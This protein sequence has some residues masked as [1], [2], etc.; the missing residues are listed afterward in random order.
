MPTTSRGSAARKKPQQ[1]A[2]ELR[3]MIVSGQLS[4]GDSLGHEPELVERFG[5]SRPSLRL[6]FVAERVVRCEQRLVWFLRWFRA[7]PSQ[8]MRRTEYQRFR[9]AKWLQHR[10]STTRWSSLLRR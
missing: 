4:E 10:R 8:L 1:I 3:A 5:V 9:F 2:D 7:S 6:Q